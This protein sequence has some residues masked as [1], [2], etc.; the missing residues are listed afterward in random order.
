MQGFDKVEIGDSGEIDDAE[1]TKL[2]E[3]LLEILTGLNEGVVPN[4][5][6]ILSGLSKSQGEPEAAD[7]GSAG[8]VEALS[9]GHGTSVQA[10]PDPAL[11]SV[12]KAIGVP[13]KPK[14]VRVHARGKQA[15][16]DGLAGVGRLPVDNGPSPIR[17]DA[18]ERPGVL[19]DVGE[20][21]APSSDPAE[22]PIQVGTAGEGLGVQRDE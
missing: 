7:V 5:H 19:L 3:R 13:Q 6:K 4:I 12:S 8:R 2:V 14:E 9:D 1:G 18:Q 11:D 20:Q 15:G 17:E 22:V 21:Q 10:G 16:E